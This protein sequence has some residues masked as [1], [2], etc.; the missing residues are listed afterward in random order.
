LI[1]QIIEHHRAH[2]YRMTYSAFLIAL[3]NSASKG[4]QGATS[5]SKQ[6]QLPVQN[7]TKRAVSM[8]ASQ[9]PLKHPPR[10]LEEQYDFL[11]LDVSL[12]RL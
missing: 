2:L 4:R 6:V 7:Q 12:G 10:T 1:E 8:E 3:R 9:L 5:V 11:A